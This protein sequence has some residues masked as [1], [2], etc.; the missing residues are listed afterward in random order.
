MRSCFEIQEP[1]PILGVVLCP[2][3]LIQLCTIFVDYLLVFVVLRIDDAFVRLFL[4]NALVFGE[5]CFCVFV[6]EVDFVSAF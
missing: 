6:V 4:D 3:L 2:S 1:V 5:Y